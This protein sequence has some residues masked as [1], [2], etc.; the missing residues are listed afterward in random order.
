VKRKKK[1]AAGQTRRGP[2]SSAAAA[3]LLEAG[4]L[5]EA[6]THCREILD[7]D[8][9]D[10]DALHV[11]GVVAQRSGH[12]DAAEAL[13]GRAAELR[14]DEARFHFGLGAFHAERRELGEAAECYRRGLRL[15]GGDVGARHALAQVLARMG[16]LQG[17]LGEYREPL[18]L[19]APAAAAPTSL[20]SALLSPIVLIDGT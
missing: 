12:A 2:A 7:E 8:P 3:R 15:S 5:A 9:D 18:L 11:L 6:E 16:D 17:S 14:P 4:E 20:S 1:S 13:L 19:A 10:A